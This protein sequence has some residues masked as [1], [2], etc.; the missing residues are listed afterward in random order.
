[1]SIAGL[2]QSGFVIAMVLLI[3]LLA[4]ARWRAGAPATR[5]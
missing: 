1:V 3:S 4:L 5:T 2:F